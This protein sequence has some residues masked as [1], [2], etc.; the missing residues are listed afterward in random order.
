[1]PIICAVDPC[2]LPWYILVLY[3]RGLPSIGADV[4]ISPLM[5][6]ICVRKEIPALCGW[7]SDGCTLNG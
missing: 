2:A 4:V 3:M 1:M 6:N 5:G 7:E